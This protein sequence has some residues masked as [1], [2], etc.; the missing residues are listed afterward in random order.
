[1]WGWIDRK[2][3]EE[4]KKAATKAIALDDKLAEGHWAFGTAKMN[5][6]DWEGAEAEYQKGLNLEPGNS[7]GLR[8]MG[9]LATALGRLD[10]A[11][12]LNKQSLALDP[13]KPITYLQIGIN[14]Y[15]SNRLDE[16]IVSF[17]KTL[18]LN[19]QFPRTH[20]FMGKVYLLQ[21]KPEIALAEMQQETDQTWK[22]YGMSLAYQALGRQKEA[23]E[24]LRNY[25][26]RF[27][28]SKLYNVAEIYAF[29]REKDKAF[30]WLEKAY[31]GREVR[32]TYLKGDPLLKNLE[33]DPRHRAFLKK[34]NLPVD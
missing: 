27:Q 1:M 15:Y 5:D 29:R 32:L 12:R 28:N 3:V 23:D 24:A 20:T 25:I 30:E 2:G 34:M 17:K 26:A 11:T 19:P 9:V 6:L 33:G 7:D 10:E 21:G 14:M 13:I 4:A 31:K 22:D 8:F 18:E 16:A